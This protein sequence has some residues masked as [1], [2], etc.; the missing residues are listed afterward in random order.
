[1]TQTNAH[2]ILNDGTYDYVFHLQVSNEFVEFYGTHGNRAGVFDAQKFHALFNEKPDAAA[3]AAKQQAAA[4]ARAGR[5]DEKAARAA[6]NRGT[7]APSKAASQGQNRGGGQG[8]AAKQD[9]RINFTH[10]C[11]KLTRQLKALDKLPA[12]VFC[13]SRRKCVE[14]A[15]AIKGMNLLVGDRPKAEPDKEKDLE[16]WF[17]WSEVSIRK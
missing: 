1:M 3:T 6:I 14:G 4:A 8:F 13:M 5:A 9:K 7:G 16:A 10:E 15:H 2:T 12:V 17:A 11:T